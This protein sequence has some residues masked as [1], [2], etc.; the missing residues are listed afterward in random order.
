MTAVLEIMGNKQ[1]LKCNDINS[2]VM[3]YLGHFI[4]SQAKPKFS[5]P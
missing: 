2:Y 3:N 4:Q 1:R 5:F